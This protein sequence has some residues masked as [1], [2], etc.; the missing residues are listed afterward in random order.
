M[1]PTES[2]AFTSSIHIQES[3]MT[4]MR[5]FAAA[6]LAST[7]LA[8]P[9]LAQSSTQP[10]NPTP[11][12]A[13]PQAPMAKP[14]T[15]A[16]APTM[17]KAGQWRTSKFVGLDV[18]NSNNEKI[19]DI[20]DLIMGDS[21]QVDTIV[22]GVGGFLG[23]GEHN[24]GLK[25]NQ[26]KFTNEAPRSASTAPATGAARTTGSAATTTA[27]PAVRDYPDHAVV[28]M[29]KDQL[30]AMPAFKYASDRK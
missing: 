26:V 27:S 25:W 1:E 20:E 30:K 13:A 14:A 22:I 15:E 10:A 19:G 16:A 5:L 11:P 8:S 28:N 12:A 29:T 6:L 4:N 21:G 9:A 23:M 18:Y 3:P 2:Q 24:V 17:Q 7:L